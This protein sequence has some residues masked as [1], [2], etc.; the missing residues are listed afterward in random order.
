M[1]KLILSEIRKYVNQLVLSESTPNLEP[2]IGVLLG[3]LGVGAELIIK[4]LRAK[5]PTDALLNTSDV[6]GIKLSR[7]IS[8]GGNRM[9][10]VLEICINKGLINSGE[11]FNII[12]TS[13]PELVPK[14]ERLFL[15]GA[16]AEFMK[17]QFNPVLGKFP[18][19]VQDEFISSI[20]RNVKSKSSSVVN[21]TPKVH[22]AFKETIYTSYLP[23][24]IKKVIKKRPIIRVTPEISLF[25]EHGKSNFRMIKSQ[26][27]RLN[28]T[29]FGKNRVSFETYWVDRTLEILDVKVNKFLNIQELSESLYK[30]QDELA[31]TYHRIKIPEPKTGLI[32]KVKGAFK[33]QQKSPQELFKINIESIYNDV[34]WVIKNLKNVVTGNW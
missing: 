16:D 10:T 23:E 17:Q 21:V 11:L 6:A 2:E 27:D 30:L 34:G 4:D 9:A 33:S 28:E 19:S 8:M 13:V 25:T 26:L 18:T 12:K 1:E 32:N 24:D 20:E 22:P 3:K 7:F 14:I 29:T 15:Q 31:I 5:F